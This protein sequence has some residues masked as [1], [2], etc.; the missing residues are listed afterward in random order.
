MTAGEA[1]IKQAIRWLDEELQ[2][3]P[4]KSKPMLVDEASRRF[5]LSPMDAEFLFRFLAERSKSGEPPDEK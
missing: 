5:N 3:N 2:D 4:D 1:P